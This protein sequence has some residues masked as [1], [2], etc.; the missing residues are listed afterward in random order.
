MIVLARAETIASAI[1]CL[2]ME[3]KWMLRRRS[4][5]GARKTKSRG[6]EQETVK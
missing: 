5:E 4:R 6:W 3:K 2:G 1:A